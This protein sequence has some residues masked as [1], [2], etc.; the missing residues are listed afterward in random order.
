M[1]KVIWLIILLCVVAPNA[2]NTNYKYAAGLILPFFLF[3]LA[4]AVIWWL[5]TKP[6]RK[7]PWQ[8]FHWLNVTSYIMVL[9]LIVSPS[10]RSLVQPMN[11]DSIADS[12]NQVHQSLREGTPPIP[13]SVPSVR[14]IKE[15]THFGVEHEDGRRAIIASDDIESLR[16]EMQKG[17]LEKRLGY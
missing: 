3:A 9:H 15:A 10:F 5:V 16:S 6:W 14:V 11:E 2:V 1:E 7:R 17:L 12:E 8:W 4:L 13:S